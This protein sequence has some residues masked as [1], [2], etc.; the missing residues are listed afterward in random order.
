MRGAQRTPH[1]EP[2]D[3]LPWRLRVIGNALALVPGKLTPGGWGPTGQQRRAEGAAWERPALPWCGRAR[4]TRASCGPRTRQGSRIRSFWEEAPSKQA[5]CGEAGAGQWFQRLMNLSPRATWNLMGTCKQIPG[6]G[7]T[8]PPKQ[9]SRQQQGDLQRPPG[10]TREIGLAPA[11]HH[12]PGTP[13]KLAAAPFSFSVFC[14]F[15]LTAN[16]QVLYPQGCPTQCPS[17]G[18]VVEQT[19][20]KNLK[21][22][23]PSPLH[24]S[25]PRGSLMKA[26]GKF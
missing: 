20:Q 23:W 13:R 12:A 10:S 3:L 7:I 21:A 5:S 25:Q 15:P 9:E 2:L 16:L 14:L 24:I 1:S 4:T 26:R 22:K 19:L 8:Y 6:K 11:F 17:G 18:K